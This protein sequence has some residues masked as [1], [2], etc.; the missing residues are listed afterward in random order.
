MSVSVVASPRNHRDPRVDSICMADQVGAVS[1]R[2]KP[3]PDDLAK[4]LRAILGHDCPG[5]CRGCENHTPKGVPIP[6]PARTE[7]N[8]LFS[9]I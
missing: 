3:R 2:F 4:E 8:H 5:R 6:L 7:E 1:G 9:E